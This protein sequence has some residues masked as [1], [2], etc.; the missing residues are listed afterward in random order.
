MKRRIIA[1]L[2]SVVICTSL[3]GSLTVSAAGYTPKYTAAAETLYEFG[4][5]KGVGKDA[6]G[7]PNFALEQKATR[8]QGL[9]MLLRLLGKEEDA[10]AYT[11]TN[12]FTDVPDWGKPYVG[13]AYENKLTNGTSATTFT[14]DGELLGKAYLTFV[15][16]ALGYDD[17]AGDFSYNDALTKAKEVALISGDAYNSAIYRD[18]CVIVSLK[19]LTTD[20]KGGK[21]T[22]AEKLV[23]DGVLPRAA[24]NDGVLTEALEAGSQPQ[25]SI[26]AS[27]IPME[28]NGNR[29]LINSDALKTA[30]PNA[31]YVQLW[32]ENKDKKINLI[33]D[34]YR[35]FLSI[36]IIRN[37]FCDGDALSSCNINTTDYVTFDI[38]NEGY[39]NFIE[40]FD[41]D[42]NLIAYTAVRSDGSKAFDT[43][44]CT[45]KYMGRA[46]AEVKALGQI[47]ALTQNDV[48]LERTVTFAANGTAQTLTLLRSNVSNV[49]HYRLYST[50]NESE[51]VK[52]RWYALV[53]RNDFEEYDSYGTTDMTSDISKY[54]SAPREGMSRTLTLIDSNKKIIGFM[55][56]KNGMALKDFADFGNGKVACT[57]SEKEALDLLS[58]TADSIGGAK[59]ETAKT[60]PYGDSDLTKYIYLY[61]TASCT[62]DEYVANITAWLN[63]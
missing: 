27:E 45:E 21:Q 7:N 37:Y 63:S 57:I 14:P 17:A 25:T 32:S 38:G 48:Y 58:K 9:V 15:L 42:F 34:P 2:L 13:Y 18:D 43:I 6:S 16:R 55:A 22:L 28:V 29:V 46:K 56:L 44:V 1:L 35:Y 31:Q 30:F 41:K 26:T 40:V 51:S 11:G 50:T 47:S 52:D 19:A 59:V 24:L 10:L 23:K 5:F 3:L 20:M 12:P 49:A 60:N 4:L 8:L 36:H 39:L 54:T 53:A 61:R 62:K 33:N